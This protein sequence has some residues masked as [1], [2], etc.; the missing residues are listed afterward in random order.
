MALILYPLENYDA[1]VSVENCDE[2]LSL[3]V[4]GSQRTLYDAL[5]DSDKEIYIR[6]STLLI[7]Q[8]I[9]LP[10]ELEQDLQTATAYLVNHSIGQVMTNDNNSG[11]IKRKEIFEVVETEYFTQGEDSDSFPSIVDSLLSQYY[12]SLSSFSFERS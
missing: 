4:I 3:N 1:F 6:Q 8:K 11:N 12:K 7:K 10:A 2:I 5:E 9:V